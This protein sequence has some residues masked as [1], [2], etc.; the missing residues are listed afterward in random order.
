MKMLHRAV[1]E[2][3]AA[4]GQEIQAS[5]VA[6]MVHRAQAQKPGKP[7]SAAAA[8]ALSHVKEN[9]GDSLDKD[10]LEH[11]Q[12]LEQAHSFAER[13]ENIPSSLLKE[14]KSSDAPLLEKACLT[15][16]V[17][18]E[19]ASHISPSDLSSLDTVLSGFS[20]SLFQ[21][22]MDSSMQ[23][24]ERL[25]EDARRS[26]EQSTQSARAQREL[27]PIARDHRAGRQ[28]DIRSE[29][30]DV[31]VDRSEVGEA[32]HEFK[33]GFEE[34]GEARHEVKVGK[35]EAGEKRYDVRVQKSEVKEVRSERS[36]SADDVA[37]GEFGKG[38]DDAGAA[39]KENAAAE[40]KGDT[41]RNSATSP[42]Q[43][44]MLS[45]RFPGASAI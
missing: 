33:V 19:Y 36:F 17:R 2:D 31:G 23:Q 28:H 8:K 27:M 40:V 25:A 38:L 22:Q 41:S 32:R 3:T 14:I 24:S 26:Q 12:K 20:T 43:A 30:F 37:D 39:L 6:S 1:T 44:A 29:R 11:I 13:G 35:Q 9:F 42:W 45:V 5:D 15:A 7:P 16:F 34:V 18:K 21:M 10:A 4:P